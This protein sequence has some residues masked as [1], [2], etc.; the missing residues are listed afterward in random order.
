MNLAK[1]GISYK[2]VEFRAGKNKKDEKNMLMREQTFQEFV[3]IVKPFSLKA[4]YLMLIYKKLVLI[5]KPYLITTFRQLAEEL[6]TEFRT[7]KRYSAALKEDGLLHYAK[8]EKKDSRI[9]GQYIFSMGPKFKNWIWKS[10]VFDVIKK[11]QNIFCVDKVENDVDNFTSKKHE[12]VHSPPL[13]F[14]KC[15]TTDHLVVHHGPLHK[16]QIPEIIDLSN[17]K[18]APVFSLSSINMSSVHREIQISP[19]RGSYY[20]EMTDEE[21]RLEMKRQL[22]MLAQHERNARKK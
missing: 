18:G 2:D 5:H 21:K 16:M 15:S 7:L 22:Q 8:L 17:E 11:D 12:V 19:K 1:Y 6:E 9:R 13:K 3:E 4:A 10:K 20:K 14:K